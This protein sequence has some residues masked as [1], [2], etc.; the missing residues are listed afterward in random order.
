M[1]VQI[2]RNNRNENKYIEVH[3]D[4][5]YH[6]WARQYME[7]KGVGVKNLLGDGYL[8]K[9]RVADM[10][11]IL[12]DYELI[13]TIETESRNYPIN[14]KNYRRGTCYQIIPDTNIDLREGFTN[15]RKMARKVKEYVKNGIDMK[16]IRV[17][18]LTN[19]IIC[20]HISQEEIL[21]IKG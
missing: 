10:S 11:S 3:T 9:Y 12:E 6:K 19:G 13:R 16:E 20:E 14:R 5:C 18:D 1:K 17:V 2:Y 21:K 15:K 4:K 8:H 7:W